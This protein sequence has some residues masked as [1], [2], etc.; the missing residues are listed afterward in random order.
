MRS[1][2]AACTSVRR[3]ADWPTGPSGILVWSPLWLRCGYF[4][5][6]PGF[7]EQ[8]AESEVEKIKASAAEAQAGGRERFSPDW[9]LR[10]F[11]M[12]EEAGFGGDL[13]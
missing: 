7:R 3:R 9:A 1:D 6:T 5:T 13:A 8:D 11:R 2:R 10:P 4:A 12:D